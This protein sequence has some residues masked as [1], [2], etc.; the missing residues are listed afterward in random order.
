M[1]MDHWVLHHHA[2]RYDTMATCISHAKTFLLPCLCPSSALLWQKNNRSPLRIVPKRGH[3]LSNCLKN[4]SVITSSKGL[5]GHFLFFN[6]VVHLIIMNTLATDLGLY[7]ILLTVCNPCIVLV[8]PFVGFENF[9]KL[10]HVLVAVNVMQ[11]N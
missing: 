6:K 3:T 2:N 4:P 5:N 10:E 11:I 9:D 7:Q 1:G 8:F